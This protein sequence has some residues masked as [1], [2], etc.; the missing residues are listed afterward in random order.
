MIVKDLLDTIGGNTNIVIRGTT[1]KDEYVDLWRGIGD[2]IKFPL[3]PYAKYEVE[4]TSVSDN[5]LIIV[6]D[7]SLNFAEMNTETVGMT[8]YIG[9]QITDLERFENFLKDMNIRYDANV[10]K[11]R[12]SIDETSIIEAEGAYGKSLDIAFAENGKFL[13]FEPWGE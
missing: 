9:N 12:I 4:H 1:E 11:N 13:G 7:S 10:F 2:D 5:I 8:A 3:V 6:L